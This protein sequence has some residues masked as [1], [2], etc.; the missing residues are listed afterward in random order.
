MRRGCC[1]PCHL[2][3]FI[4]CSHLFIYSSNYFLSHWGLQH[5]ALLRLCWQL[6]FLHPSTLSQSKA[7]QPF[8]RVLPLPCIQ[9]LILITDGTQREPARTH[10]VRAHGG[11]GLLMS[12]SWAVGSG[13]GVGDWCISQSGGLFRWVAS[14]T[15]NDT[16]WKPLSASHDR[17]WRWIASWM[18][19]DFVER[20]VFAVIISHD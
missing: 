9:S 3:G 15:N 2:T 17:K 11:T 13:Q 5:L 12:A 14:R 4:L 19:S 16:W 10:L 6:F 8:R 7:R 20:E 1:S 18:G